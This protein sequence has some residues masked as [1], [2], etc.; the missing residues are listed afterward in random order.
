VFSR[1]STTGAL[2]FLEVHENGVAGDDGLGGAD[3]AEIRPDG[4]YIFTPCDGGDEMGVFARNTATGALTFVQ[5][6]HDGVD[7]VDGLNRARQAV[8]SPDG[9]YLYVTASADHSVAT[10]RQLTVECSPTP[11]AGCRTPVASGKARLKIK[12]APTD[13]QDALMWRWVRGAATTA[14]EFGDPAGTLTDYALCVYDASATPQPLVEAAVRAGV[15]CGTD[16]ATPCWRTSAAAFTYKDVR[17][18]P[19][20]VSRAKLQSGGAGGARVLVR[21]RGE[22]V[23]TPALP[24]ALPVR[25]QMQRAG[26]ALCWEAVY[27][28]AL[29]NDAGQFVGKAD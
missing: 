9:T 20:G 8:V 1:N 25:A 19:D 4:A 17:R 27:G 6:L 28:T 12:D 22:N 13:T 24:L 3:G 26:S 2:T 21:A 5:V 15:G 11:L 29:R 14:G 16:G 23:K 7:G 18:S 10:F